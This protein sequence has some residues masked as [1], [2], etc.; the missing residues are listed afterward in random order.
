MTGY[1]D[2]DTPSAAEE[3]RRLAAHCLTSAKDVRIKHQRH[4]LLQMV[5][6][7]TRMAEHFEAVARVVEAHPAMPRDHEGRW[8]LTD[9]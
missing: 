4:I 6:H 5:E 3:Y 9:K 7:W 1:A 8:R 2:H